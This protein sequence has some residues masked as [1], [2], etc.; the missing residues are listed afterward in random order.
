MKI[1]CAGGG[2]AGLYSAIL[3]KPRDTAHDIAVIERNRPRDTSGRGVVPPDETPGNLEAND[4]LP[5]RAI[6]DNF[7]HRDDTGVH[8]GGEAIR[9]GDH[10][11]SG[12]GRKRLRNIPQDRADG[13]GVTPEFEKEADGLD[14]CRDADLVI[15]PDGVNSRIRTAHA[16]AFKPDIDVRRNRF[17][18]PGKRKPF[19][20]FTFV[21]ERTGHGWIRVHAYRFQPDL[22][23]FIA[24]CPGEIRTASGFGATLT[25]E[26]TAVPEKVF[27]DHLD[28]NALMSDAKHLRG[29]AWPNFP[30]VSCE[31]RSHGNIVLMAGAAHKAHFSIGPGTKPAMKDA[32]GPA[33]LPDECGSREEA[34]ERYENARRP[35]VPR[36]QSAARNSTE[37]F[38]DI[39]RYCGLEPMQFT[40]SLPTRSQRVS[41]GNLRPRDPGW[42]GE[43]EKRFLSK[44]SGGP[45]NAPRPP[46]FA[47]FRPRGTEPA[48]RVAVSPMSMYPAHDR[49]PGDFHM[50][51]YGARARGGAGL[52][53]PGHEAAWRRIVDF[54]HGQTDAK[55]AIQPGHAGPKGSTRAAR[56]GMDEPLDGGDRDIAAPSAVPRPDASGT[57]GAMTRD[58][59]DRVRA[60][61]LAAAG[62]PEPHYAHGYL[63]P[64]FI[65]PLMNRR[66]DEYGGSPENRL[67]FPIA[68]FLAVREVRPG[69]KPVPA[70][71]SANDWMRDEDVTPE[72][73]V[74]IAAAFRHAGAGIIDVSAGQTSPRARPVHGRM[75]QTPFPD[76]IRNEAG[77]ATMAAGNIREPG[78][79]NSIPMAGP[80]DIRCL[81]RPH[82]SD[83]NRTLR[84]AAQQGYG[85]Q[86]RPKQ[87]LTGKAQLERNPGRAADMA[88]IRGLKTMTGSGDR[89]AV[90]TGGGIGAAAAGTPASA[91]AR[92]TVMGRKEGPAGEMAGR[93]E[94]EQAVTRDV[95]DQ[96]SV[97]AAFAKARDGS[98]PVQILINNAGPAGSARSGAIA[99]DHWETML[100]VNLTGVF[101]CTQAVPRE[102]TDAGRGRIVT[103]AGT[104]GLTG[105]AYVAAYCA[106]KHGAAGMTRALALEIERTGVTANAVCPGYT[107]TD[108]PAA[109]PGNIAARTGLSI[110][111]A[112]KTLPKDNPQGRSVTPEEAAETVLWPCGGGAAS[113]NGRAIAIDGGGVMP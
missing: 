8:T 60:D 101:P 57:P 31:R 3:M 41:R 36:L 97:D 103:V 19:D 102:M 6:L 111:D 42:L 62:M 35:E 29:P 85:D 33:R 63:M 7:A 32:I 84:A 66:E 12:I 81:A 106:A 112:R 64:A 14:A 87:Y 38:E 30:R 77:I 70:R 18:R 23:A 46:M 37:R 28:G 89:H 16:D 61:H 39:G 82:P 95:T 34:F 56:E 20:A 55:F 94:H 22:P 71:I 59:M 51:H 26:T 9:P 93:L 80:A 43:T 107:E 17:I 54:V 44:A 105:Y 21:F 75:F 24:G 1:V 40:Y 5:A 109:P 11:F 65:T 83:P 25:Q 96:A 69:G 48:N 99:G 27:A 88:A 58:D 52:Y 74:R 76:R 86:A 49:T 10:G 72:E 4:P 50:V 79:V 67:R 78:H 47:P 91:G 68:V 53:K 108:M 2:P 98:G 73:A 90:I 104:A 113:I 13:P 100:P 45:V 15:A 92:I 110:R